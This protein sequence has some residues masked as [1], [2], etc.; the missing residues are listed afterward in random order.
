MLQTMSTGIKSITSDLSHIMLLIVPRPISI[1]M[2]VIPFTLSIHPGNG[3]AM[4]AVTIDGRIMQIGSWWWYSA[5]ICSPI[6]LVRVYVFGCGPYLFTFKFIN[7]LYGYVLEHTCRLNAMSATTSVGSTFTHLINVST[8]ICSLGGYT[9]S[10][11]TR[12]LGLQNAVDTWMMLCT[13]ISFSICQT[14]I[15]MIDLPLVV[16]FSSTS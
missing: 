11:T 10:S 6:D 2:P 12:R 16:S 7:L 3:S 15:F 13:I 14:N 8:S 5:A 1:I 9:I 4:A